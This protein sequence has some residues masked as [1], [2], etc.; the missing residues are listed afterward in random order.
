MAIDNDQLFQALNQFEM[1]KDG[2]ALTGQR[3]V[4]HELVL[5]HLARL[6]G[7]LY[8]NSQVFGLCPQ[9]PLQL[10]TQEKTL[11]KL[12][13][14]TN[15]GKLMVCEQANI[16]ECNDH[17]GNQGLFAIALPYPFPNSQPDMQPTFPL[18]QVKLEWLAWEKGEHEVVETGMGIPLGRMK[19]GQWDNQYQPPVV[20]LVTDKVLQKETVQREQM[21]KHLSNDIKTL[22]QNVNS[23]K[24]KNHELAKLLGNLKTRQRTWAVSLALLGVCLVGGLVFW[25]TQTITSL[26]TESS[27]L[28]VALENQISG[29][30]ERHGDKL[31]SQSNQLTALNKKH[32]QSKKEFKTHSTEM[33]TALICTIAALS[34][35]HD[36]DLKEQSTQLKTA[37]AGKVDALKTQILAQILELDE[38][39]KNQSR[40]LTILTSQQS[41]DKEKLEADSSKLKVDLEKQI[42]GLAEQHSDKL[43]SQSRQLTSLTEQQSKSQEKFQANSSQLKVDLE[44]QISGLAKR[45]GDKLESQSRQL[46]SLT[47]QQSKDKEKLEADSSKLKV[48]LEKQ[49]SGLAKRHEQLKN[50]SSQL[51]E[52]FTKQLKDEIGPINTSVEKLGE[53]ST[54]LETALTGKV[55]ALK[56]QILELDEKLKN[57]SRQLAS[58]TSPQSK[59][60]KEPKADS[61]QVGAAYERSMRLNQLEVKQ[62]SKLPQLTNSDNNKNVFRDKLKDDSYGP[63]MVRIPDGRFLMG[64]IQGGGN[65]D[66]HPVHWVSIGKFAMGRYEVTF[67]EYD[68]FAKATSRIKPNDKGWG[69]GNR[70]VINV[71]WY[72]AV[73][74]TNWLS[75]QTGKKYRLPSEAEWEYASRAG[76]NTK[77]WWGNEIGKNNANC[78]GCGSR[79]D[80]KQQ[81]ASVG[82]FKSNKFG[83]YD[84]IGNVQEWVADNW[85]KNYLDAPK[86]GRPWKKINSNFK[87]LR[88]NSWYWHYFNVRV[89]YR[90]KKAPNHRGDKTG[91]R[92]ARDVDT[93]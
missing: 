11:S 17:I 45:H 18:C 8:W 59:D 63:Q 1:W 5:A 47:S 87:V 40:Q 68:T 10:N 88:S 53:K 84:T 65:P 89:S 24:D 67:D 30:A 61:S 44:K 33:K 70:P 56:K 73:A 49:I 46:T 2:D 37:L 32:D 39:L 85:H 16:P 22:E 92:V 86:N 20:K 76:T 55:D 66:E 52:N 51:V 83:L 79:W 7:S 29:L 36:K 62:K 25:H 19:E 14:I 28:K 15:T 78:N 91:F 72:D 60:K 34:K 41:E 75:R 35:K 3:L 42:S 31:E 9:Y 27:Q 50:Q 82:S 4:Q 48:D 54:Q 74:Y 38:K 6:Y 80:N 90:V 12:V 58:L 69:R 64:D 57:Q 26:E 13:A 71:T 77:Y 43:E 21:E 23:L 81:T 93:E